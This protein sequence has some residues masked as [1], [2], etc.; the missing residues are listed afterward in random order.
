MLS[1][2][3]HLE[4]RW[5]R[6]RIVADRDGDDAGSQTDRKPSAAVRSDSVSLGTDGI[7]LGGGTYVVRAVIAE[8]WGPR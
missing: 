1:G 5:A 2:A 8:L 4:W 7:E 6:R 3:P